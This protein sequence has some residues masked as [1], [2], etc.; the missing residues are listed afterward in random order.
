MLTDQAFA[1]PTTHPSLTT[2]EDLDIG[3]RRISP[4]HPAHVV[5][6]V[7]R[8][9]ALMHEQFAEAL[10]VDDMAEAAWFSKYHFTRLFRDV[11][12]VSPGRYLAAVRMA[13]AKHLLRTT[14]MK[15]VD[16]TVGI[17]YSSVG[18]FSSRF[19]IHVGISPTEYRARAHGEQRAHLLEAA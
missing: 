17:G 19:R 15:V 7:E 18:T 12:G 10:T 11:T 1:V 5:E 9:K 4:A 16:I 2:I 3:P 6:A 13:H 8:A 14:Q